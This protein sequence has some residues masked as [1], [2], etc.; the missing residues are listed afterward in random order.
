RAYTA[1]DIEVVTGCEHIRRRPGMY[2]GDTGRSGLHS[3][4]FMLLEPGLERLR[5]AE[6]WLHADGSATVAAN[7]TAV[8][9]AALG[10][11][12]TQVGAM[13]RAS[14]WLSYCGVSAL[15]EWCVAE[16]RFGGR[17]FEQ[18]YE[19][20]RIVTP[21]CDRGPAESTGLSIRFKPDPEIFPEP[22]FDPELI[23]HRLA[24]VAFPHRGVSIRLRDERDGFDHTYC[25][26]RGLLD[27]LECRGGG[28]GLHPP[29]AFEDERE[30][31]TVEVALCY[32]DD[33]GER[34]RAFVNGGFTP[35]N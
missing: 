3:L 19:R 9:P 16:T 13:C 15:S 28:V 2:I 26:T 25:S 6:V 32:C 22:K 17:R 35:E 33:E 21:V 30:G 24:G 11:M 10:R 23:E 31:I 4:V 12:M 1:A 18:R 20:G 7:G 27:M 34:R 29:I 14:H 5:E 8:D